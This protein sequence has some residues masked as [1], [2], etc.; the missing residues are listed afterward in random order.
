M[1][2][3]KGVQYDTLQL[4]IKFVARIGYKDKPE[5]DKNGKL[6][7]CRL[8]HFHAACQS[9]C[10]D[11]VMKFLEFG[12]D[13]NCIWRETG[14]TPLHLALVF[15]RKKIVEMLLMRDVN[16]FVPNKDGLTSLHVVCRNFPNAHELVKM[17][18]EVSH[19]VQVDA[20]D[21]LGKTPLHYALS[22]NHKVQ[23]TVRLLLENGASPNLA[24]KEG[25][26]PLHYIFKRS[27]VFFDGYTVDDL[28]I[29]FKINED[30]NQKV[31][32]DA[33]DKLGN[34]PL[35]LALECVGRNIKKVVEVLL[36][37]GA[38]PNVANAEGST[39]LHLICDKPSVY[40]SNEGLAELFFKINDERHQQVQVNAKDNSGQTPLQLAVENVLPNA[41]HALV[42]HDAD[43][44]NFL[45][46]TKSIEARI[47]MPAELKLK[48]ISGVLVITEHLEN[49][50]YEITRSHALNSAKFMMVITIFL[51]FFPV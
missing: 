43:L 16:P 21:N 46:T 22:R 39:P 6:V 4:F 27:G 36:R 40:D 8:T 9:G 11:I 7:S 19:P 31:E 14:D 24:D 44:S 23:N 38:D 20:Q 34:T 51:D 18:L 2:Y 17:L 15:G 1:N 48:A 30:Q 37:R 28:K 50:G 35:H 25:L 10:D 32:V 29:F 26:T 42:D 12:Q 13:P 47:D 49:G 41:V 45:F 33:Q 3:W 5:V